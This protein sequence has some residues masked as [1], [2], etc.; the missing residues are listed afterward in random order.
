VTV[1]TAESDALMLESLLIRFGW[2][3]VIGQPGSYDVWTPQAGREDDDLIV[4][5]DPSR[6][7]FP[8]LVTQ[9][10]RRLVDRY[11]RQ[12][13]GAMALFRVGQQVGLD[14]TDWK[15]E[16]PLPGI[17]S[18]D[19][20]QLLIESAR[21]QL[22]ASA[23]STREKRSYH[24]HSSAFV[25]QTFLSNSYMG[26]TDIGSF[27]ISAHTPSQ[28]RLHLTKRSETLA[29]TQPRDAET[30][31]GAAILRTFEA[32]LTA[33]RIGLDEYRA[34]QRLEVFH[35]A[36]DEGVSHEFLKALGNF[37]RD[38]DSGVSIVRRSEG[39]TTP[40]AELTF[41]PTEA[42]ILDR[43]ATSLVQEH[44]PR[45]VTV[46]GEVTDLGRRE[47]AAGRSNVIRIDVAKGG[48]ANSV[49]VHLGVDEY[50][51]A[52][53]VHDA[54]GW[55]SVTGVMVREGNL[56]WI[57]HPSAVDVVDRPVQVDAADDEPLEFEPF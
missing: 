5:R 34:N 16:T 49:R 9:A 8:A 40:S 23:K 31:S 41:N 19:D 54:E 50:R 47:G 3:R 35:E 43:A 55:L 17:I 20:G 56:S 36:I 53:A 10:T 25:A 7:D 21:A 52:M 51:L 2:E 12:A 57:Y 46:V 33:V 15:K 27:I 4:P 38:G 32:A 42:P 14:E 22:A 48:A 24:G 29:A 45:E 1:G 37:V 18:W 11:G 28:T 13:E 6:G 44:Q 26:Q 39:R 30:V